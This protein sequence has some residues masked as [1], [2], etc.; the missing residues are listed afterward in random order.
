MK[1]GR[2]LLFAAAALLGSQVWAGGGPS[3]AQLQAHV[4]STQQQEKANDAAQL[5][6]L[7]SLY[8][9]AMQV[10]TRAVESLV[11][12]G[13]K[14][15]TTSQSEAELERDT[16]SGQSLVF[17]VRPTAYSPYIS[18]EYMGSE[19]MTADQYPIFEIVG[20]GE[21]MMTMPFGP[22]LNS[23]SDVDQS[24]VTALVSDDGKPLDSCSIRISFDQ[25]SPDSNGSADEGG[26]EPLACAA[27]LKGK[28]DADLITLI[29]KVTRKEILSS[30][31]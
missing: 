16:G 14:L 20:G 1:T 23:L 6:Y 22:T 18:E 9:H 17:T 26:T 30:G 4:L 19:G 11:K 24:V 5:R 27:F 15:K 10:F 3:L 7:K 31:Q 8:R 12:S 25:A 21:V 28:Y 2:A 29:K 13:V